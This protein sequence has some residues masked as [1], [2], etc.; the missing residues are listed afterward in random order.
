MSD[1][2]IDYK[3]LLNNVFSLNDPTAHIKAAITTCPVEVNSIEDIDGIVKFMSASAN[4]N[5][6]RCQKNHQS[7]FFLRENFNIILSSLKNIDS[8]IGEDSDDY[9]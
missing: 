6:S 9:I 4:R 7:L 3:A 8:V 5:I 1:I 2:S